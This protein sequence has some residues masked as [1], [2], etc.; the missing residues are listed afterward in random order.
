MDRLDHGRIPVF[1]VDE[2]EKFQRSFY[3]VRSA[4]GN[5][6]CRV[7]FAIRAKR[8]ARAGAGRQRPGKTDRNTDNYAG[9]SLADAD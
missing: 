1:T 7:R 5:G 4:S 8:E 3:N 9:G 2:N 6:T